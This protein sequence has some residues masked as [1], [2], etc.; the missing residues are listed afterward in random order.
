M[1]TLM[2]T[3]AYSGFLGEGGDSQKRAQNFR[4]LVML[5]EFLN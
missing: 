5:L 2:Y 4:K 3:S 1:F